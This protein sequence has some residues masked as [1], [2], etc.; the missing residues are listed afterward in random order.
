MAQGPVPRQG[1]CFKGVLLDHG[2]QQCSKA[3]SWTDLGLIEPVRIRILDEG[4]DSSGFKS[5]LIHPLGPFPLD[6]LHIWYT[7]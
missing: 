6:Q 2:S 5:P 7:L 3:C 4:S 1:R